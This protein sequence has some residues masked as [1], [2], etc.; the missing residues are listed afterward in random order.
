MELSC[1]PPIQI[2]K[3]IHPAKFNDIKLYI[4]L[5]FVIK[6]AWLIATKGR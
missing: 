2:K 1:K 6:K 4:F 3:L 5:K